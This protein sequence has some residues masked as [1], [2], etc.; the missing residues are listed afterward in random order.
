M[1]IFNWNSYLILAK[2]LAK[3]ITESN[4]RSSVS[5]AYYSVYCLSRNYA[6]SQGLQNIQSPK[7]H[8]KVVGFYKKKKKMHAI[9][10]NLGR[11]RDLRNQCDY[12]DSVS[13]LDGKVLLSLDLADDILTH[14][15]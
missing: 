2:R 13:G 1:T 4:K 5:R 9:V 10:G 15:P 3:N 14:L 7:M 8:G 6:I 12:D 11:L